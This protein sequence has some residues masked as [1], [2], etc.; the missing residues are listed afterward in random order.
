MHAFDLLG[1]AR[2]CVDT[3]ALH[4][5]HLLGERSDGLLQRTDEPG[6]L[7]ADRPGVAARRI[8]VDGGE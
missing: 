8:L 7:V 5:I 4:L 1:Q 3:V 2:V 6:D